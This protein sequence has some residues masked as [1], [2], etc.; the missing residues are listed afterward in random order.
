MSLFSVGKLKTEYLE[1]LLEKWTWEDERIILG[2][3]IGEDVTVID[4]GDKYLVVKTDPITFTSR[5]PG[6]YLVN[7]NANDV[8]T[9]GA[10]PRWFLT[11][12]LLP[13]NKTDENLVENIF[14]QISSA[15]RKLGISWCGGH[16][17]I[18]F[19]LDKPILVGEMLGEVEK[20]NL[21]TTSGAKAGDDL[22]LTKGVAIEAT[23][24]IAREKKEELKKS[25]PTEFLKRAE[26]YLF[27]PGIG[28]MEDALIA[29]QTAPVH[30]MHDPTEGGLCMGLYELARAAGVGILVYKEKIP[31]FPESEI[32]CK[33]YH[34]NPLQAIASGAL[35]ITLSPCYTQKVI[36]AL[37]FRGI[38]CACIGKVTSREEGL[39]MEEKRRRKPLP[40]S[41][42][43]D[44]T[45]L[46]L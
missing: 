16:T 25:F 10:R 37:K 8:A 20:E 7:I 4:F 38:P 9:S 19:G 1:R 46:Y 29:C 30:S 18:T 26:N 34:I 27:N 44:I 23:S 22:L 6:W 42:T 14:R 12:L 31:L 11:T 32:L 5:E 33:H 40:Y 13:E 35:L 15:C 36:D 2:P 28:V 24:I 45:K 41:E 39:I 43:D 3:K 17:E 21:I